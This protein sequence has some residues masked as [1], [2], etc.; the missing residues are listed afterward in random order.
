MANIYEEIE[1]ED[2][3]FDNKTQMYYYPCPCGDKFQISLLELYDGEDI[4]ECPSCTL[5][6]RIIY[7]EDN[8]PELKEVE[9]VEDEEEDEEDAD[10]DVVLKVDKE[11]NETTIDMKKCTME[12]VEVNVNVNVNTIPTVEN[13]VHNN[14]TDCEERNNLMVNN[15]INIQTTK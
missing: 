10:A 4:G 5:K 8:L 11:V 15:E 14:I 6:I 1:I 13:S 7:D 3:T 9:E 2:M 12:V